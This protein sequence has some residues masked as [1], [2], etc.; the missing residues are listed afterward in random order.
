[1]SNNAQELNNK[2]PNLKN[3]VKY[4]NQ[5]IELF[6][7]H[8]SEE[9]FEKKDSD[10]H[11]LFVS[12][13][14]IYT[15]S[16]NSNYNK[17]DKKNS[18]PTQ[19]NKKNDSNEEIEK[20]LNKHVEDRKKQKLMKSSTEKLPVVTNKNMTRLES[21][22]HAKQIYTR[23]LNEVKSSPEAPKKCN[24]QYAIIHKDTPKK[25]S[26]CEKSKNKFKK[27]NMYV[28]HYVQNENRCNDSKIISKNSR[29]N[30]FKNSSKI[31]RA[32][33]NYDDYIDMYTNNDD[34]T[35]STIDNTDD[36]DNKITELRRLLNK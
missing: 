33:Q 15:E 21:E 10:L 13:F 9:Q 26:H 27:D 34:L 12:L 18:V 2:I 16:E 31:N 23:C 6:D 19:I 25:I 8:V 28:K 32:V 29:K 35:C 20:L 7:S 3:F 36:I 5:T 17:D 4:L 14:N 1:M 24:K 22:K 30:S 11:K